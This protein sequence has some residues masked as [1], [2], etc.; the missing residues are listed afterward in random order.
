[1]TDVIVCSAAEVDYTEALTWYAK[2]SV[3]V[4]NDFGA[5]FDRALT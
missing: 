4:A 5:E 3:D 2:R 1:M